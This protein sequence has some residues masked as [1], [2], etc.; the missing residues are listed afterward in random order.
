MPEKAKSNQHTDPSAGHDPGALEEAERKM[1]LRE[2][3]T[4][5]SNVDPTADSSEEHD[6]GALDEAERKMLRREDG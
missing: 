4:E 5:T 2:D 3:A 6:P 1:L